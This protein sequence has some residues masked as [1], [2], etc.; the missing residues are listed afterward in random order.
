MKFTKLAAAV[1]I[2]ITVVTGGAQAQTVISQWTFETNPPPDL[3]NSMMGP[4]VTADVGNGTATGFHASALTDWSTPAGNGSANSYSS[5]TWAPADYYQ[6]SLS[7]VGFTGIWVTFSQTSSATGPTSFE[8]QYSTNGGTSFTTFTT[9]TVGTAGWNTTTYNPASQYV[10]DLSS[11]TALNENAA[12]A[13]RLV[14]LSS[15]AAGGTSRVDD[16][17]V[18]QGGPIVIPEPATYLL[19][20][21]GLLFCAQRFRSARKN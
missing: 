5:N 12:I 19:F 6:F 21:I 9:Y 14:N 10:F 3:S 20:G 17:Y 11:I 16:F 4:S 13:F 2:A 18:S 1:A 15:P 8:L 7:T